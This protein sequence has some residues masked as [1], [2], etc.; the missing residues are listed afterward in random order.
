MCNEDLID[1]LK[2]VIAKHIAHTDELRL[3]FTDVEESFREGN[4][5]AD[6]LAEVSQVIHLLEA[7]AAA[8]ERALGG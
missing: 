3:R 6:E 5:G 4:L 2:E 8:F 7:D 1:S